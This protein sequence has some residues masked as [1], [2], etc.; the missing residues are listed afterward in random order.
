M[1]LEEKLNMVK[2]KGYKYNPESGDFINPLG[3]IMKS[4]KYIT[5]HPTPKTSISAHQY[6]WWIMTGEIPNVIDHINRDKT[7]NRFCNLRNVTTQQNSFNV[8]SKGYY[9]DKRCGSYYARIKH[10]YKLIYI[11]SFKTEEEARKAYLDAKQK[12]HKI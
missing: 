9:Y 8:E 10:N 5:I 12:Y 7:D 2:E 3:N 1:N 4:K 6:A 11:G